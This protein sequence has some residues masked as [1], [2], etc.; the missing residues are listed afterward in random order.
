M[1]FDY[2]PTAV[3]DF[4]FASE[5]S[6]SK[7][8]SIIDGSLPFPAAGVTGILLFGTYG[9]GK[10]ALAKLLPCAIESRYGNSDPYYRYEEIQRGND[11]AKVIQSLE[12]QLSLVPF[13]AQYHYIVLDE[14]DNLNR[15]TMPSLKLLMNAQNAVFILTTNN[16]T[17]VDRGVLDRCHCLEFNAARPEQWL[18]LFQRIISDQKRV[19]PPD[20]LVLNIISRCD[21]SARKIINAAFQCAKHCALC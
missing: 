11:G 7:L 2:T 18:P 17:K 14:V 9:T 13:P 1:T 21:G 6:R 4:V 19:T 10:S 15:D 5:A 16:I 12:T 8:M 20:E 3:S